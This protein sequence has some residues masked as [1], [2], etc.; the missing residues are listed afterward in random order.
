MPLVDDRGR[1]FGRINLIDGLIAVL[2][3][4]LIP[5]A[6]GAYSLFREPEPRMRMVEPTHVTPATTNVRIEGEHLR[7]FLRVSFNN[8]QGSTFALLS[9]TTAEVRVPELPSGTYD[10]V[11]YDVAREVHRLPNAITVEAAPEQSS[12]GR[13]LV[14]GSF[15]AI[16]RDAMAELREGVA[17]TAVGGSDLEILDIGTERPDTRWIATG[18]GTVEVLLGGGNQLPAL[19]RATCTIAKSRCQVGGI[20]LEPTFDLSLFTA[21]G[22][23]VRFVVAEAAADGPTL[24]AEIAVRL[25]APAESGNL[26]RPGD[27]D[28]GSPLWG[29]RLGTVLAVGRARSVSAQTL[30]PQLIPW[31]SAGEW[32][33][34]VQDVVTVVDVRIRAVLDVTGAGLQYR[35]RSIRTGGPFL[36]QTDRYVTRGWVV[37]VISNGAPAIPDEPAGR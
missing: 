12:L 23:P 9:P 34:T 13:M 17:L 26:I 11:L 20:D 30:V 15:V 27:Q 6:Y 22:R 14:A 24:H 3:I 2:L 16:D 21:S 32:H 7:P 35:G 37:N 4:G 8:V 25:V 19:L 29:E 5:L 36:F 18:D 10:V 28:R 33:V 1:L 31:F